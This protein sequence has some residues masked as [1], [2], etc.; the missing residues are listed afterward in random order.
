MLL[1][2]INS[3][4]KIKI[5]VTKGKRKWCDYGINWEQKN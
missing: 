5:Y 3:S 4:K 1:R 2:K